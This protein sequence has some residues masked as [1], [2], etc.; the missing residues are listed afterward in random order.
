M[1]IPASMDNLRR[2]VN[3]SGDVVDSIEYLPLENIIRLM[4]FDKGD[5]NKWVVDF[6]PAENGGRVVVRRCMA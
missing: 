6:A 5:D 4:Y 1:N 3:A 2:D